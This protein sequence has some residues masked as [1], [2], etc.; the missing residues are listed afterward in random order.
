MEIAPV[1]HRATRSE[2]RRLALGLLILAPVVLLLLLPP[3]LGLERFVVTD[4]GMDG[5]V[6]RG[7]VVLT[8]EVPPTDLRVGDV[9]TFRPPGGESDE[10]VTRRIVAIDDGVATT[11]ADT[12]GARDPWAV[13]LDGAAYA[14]VWVGLPWI[15]YPF[16]LDGGWLL[17]VGAAAGALTLA[18]TTARRAPAKV[19]G[20]ARARVTVG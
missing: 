20:P 15:G 10:M 12:T 18:L 11:Q 19:A 16:V 7:S 8:R 5:S 13:P 14:R 2:R 1:P 9:I 17:L 3:A 4:H 6:G